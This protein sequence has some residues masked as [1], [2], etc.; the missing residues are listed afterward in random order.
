MGMFDN[1]KYEHN[2]EKCGEPLVDFQSKDADCELNTLTPD[3]VEHFYT[4][5]G[6]CGTWH[7]FYVER[8]C[9]VKEITVEVRG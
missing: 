5:C 6:N 1:I 8:E 7:N 4:S 2:C 3:K 9:V